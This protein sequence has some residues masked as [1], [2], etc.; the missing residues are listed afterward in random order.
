MKSIKSDFLNKI[1]SIA[2]AEKRRQPESL[3]KIFVIIN[4][5]VKFDHLYIQYLAFKA[6]VICNLL[7]FFISILIFKF[8]KTHETL[9][10]I[11]NDF[12]KISLI[13]IPY[14]LFMFFVNIDLKDINLLPGYV[15]KRGQ[16]INKNFFIVQIIIGMVII[17]SG[18]YWSA[19]FPEK[20][21][22]DRWGFSNGFFSQIVFGFIYAYLLSV[23][24]Y[25]IY[26]S[27]L[28]IAWLIINQ[29]SRFNSS[30]K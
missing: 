24:I 5:N 27:F 13:L 9:F 2:P 23:G 12:T 6:A 3:G 14:F 16:V 4:L 26:M 21:F 20:I 15:K 17:F 22:F 8:S 18:I 29:D 11:Y 19:F 30:K 1:F 25:T 28:I 10:E 7:A